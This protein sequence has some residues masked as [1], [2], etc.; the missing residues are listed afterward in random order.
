MAEIFFSENKAIIFD[1]EVTSWPGANER[2]WSLPDEHREIIQVGA[3]KIETEGEMLEINNF[4][5]LVR[6]QI[7][8][9][10]SDYIINLTG[11]TQKNI[12]RDG[13]SFPLALSRFTNFI[14]EHPINIFCNGDDK[15]VIEENC[16][17][18]SRPFPSILTKTT[19]L[20]NYFSEILGVSRKE[21]I[22]GKLPE[23]FGFKNNG[24]IHTG[25]GD[26]KSISQALRHIR[27]KEKTC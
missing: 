7:N 25:L 18:H 10:L 17:I 9:I 26:A 13:I 19:D 22:S 6:P 5:V 21:C 24:K 16:H 8:P 4:Q 23:L 12:E 2:N 3:V 15:D 14:G 27:M 1:L 20:K 11:I